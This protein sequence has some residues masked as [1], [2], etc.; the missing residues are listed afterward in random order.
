MSKKRQPKT[1]SLTYEDWYLRQGFIRIV[2]IDEAGRGAWAGPVAAGTVCLPISDA[3]LPELLRGVRDSKEMTAR[4]RHIL[5]EQIKSVA[6]AWGVGSATSTEID[7]LGIVPATKLAM[8]RATEAMMRDFSGFSPDCLFLDS[9]N[10][11]NAPVACKQV[12]IRGGDKL[13]LSVA[14]ASVLAKTWRDDHMRELE[15]QYPGY[16]FALHKGYGTTRHRAAIA[17]QGPSPIHRMYYKPL[18]ALK[19]DH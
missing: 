17:Q 15:Q 9:V 13:S 19:S 4:Q 6:V 10:W 7:D 8:I 1:A 2:G 12:N 14:A 5:V 3:S 18:Q 11:D 16:D